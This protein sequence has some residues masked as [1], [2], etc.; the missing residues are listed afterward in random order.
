MPHLLSHAPQLSLSEATVLQLPEQKS[1]PDEQ[2]ETVQ[3]PA[4]QEYFVE[5]VFFSSQFVQESPQQVLVPFLT[6]LMDAAVL[7]VPLL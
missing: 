1:S 3:V 7:P 2:A 6:Q 5:A 4:E